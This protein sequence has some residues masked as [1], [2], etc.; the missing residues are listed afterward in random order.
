MEKKWEFSSK[1]LVPF[2]SKRSRA[3][4]TS[5]V[6]CRA[7]R[8][9]SF[10]SCLKNVK[11]LCDEPSK[12]LQSL[13]STKSG[14]LKTSF[15]S[16]FCYLTPNAGLTLPPPFWRVSTKVGISLISEIDCA[17]WYGWY[18]NIL[19]NSFFGILFLLVL[20]R[21]AMH[22]SCWF[23]RLVRRVFTA[24]STL[25]QWTVHLEWKN[26]GITQINLL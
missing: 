7:G 3:F 4:L 22:T 23:V 5:L 18:T 9:N 17:F 8:K 15:W 14:R 19:Y 6:Q 26:Y 1:R 25:L 20:H 10:I 13:V 16:A 21:C 12:R 24:F 2:R 11:Q